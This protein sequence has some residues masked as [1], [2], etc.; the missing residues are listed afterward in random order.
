MFGSSAALNL[1]AVE[2]NGGLEGLVVSHCWYAAVVLFG[3]RT[4]ARSSLPVAGLKPKPVPENGMPLIKIRMPEA[5]FPIEI[6]PVASNWKLPFVGLRPT[7]RVLSPISGKS[8]KVATHPSRCC[9]SEI[10]SETH[11]GVLVG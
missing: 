5:M 9:E 6:E 10:E 11:A 8:R 3:S 2:V 1:V 7:I 4:Y